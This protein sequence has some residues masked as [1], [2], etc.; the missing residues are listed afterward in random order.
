MAKRSGPARI[1][2]LLENHPYPRDTRV[3]LHAE[4]LASEGYQVTVISPRG[5]GQPG[6][7]VVNGV[8][9]YHFR[10]PTG[11]TSAPAFLLE[12]SVA[13]LMMTLLTLWVWL[14]RGL[15]IL[16]IYN[17][18]DSLFVAGLLPRLMGKTIIYDLRDLAPETYMAKFRQPSQALYRAQLWLERVICQLAHHVVTV[19]ESYRQLV[20]RRDGKRPEQVTIVRQGPNLDRMQGIEPDQ[21]IRDRAGSIIAFL[22]NM[23]AQDGI[24][25]LLQALHHL[26]RLGHTDWY[27]LLIGP[28]DDPQG[29]L[30]MAAELG[31]G[32]RVRL[33][34]LLAG[35][36]WMRLVAAA[37]IGVEPAPSNVINDLCTVNKIMDYMAFS[38]PVV[39]YDLPEHRVTAGDTALYA[40]GND[41]LN[42]AQKIAALIE[43]PALRS[44]L[45]QQGRRRVEE[46]LAWSF[47]RTRLLSLYREIAGGQCPEA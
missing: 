28:A 3:W 40:E 27:C 29:I 12:Y 32:E 21:S 20:I 10:L 47:Q 4:A 7:E 18:P 11:G 1:T 6:H 31:L 13:T 14:R 19:N 15:D 2:I 38:K 37:D 25:H 22:G 9:A 16:T 30:K 36:Q 24:D 34:G 8:R 39:A 33:T 23:S 17:P 5:K 26:G 41:P 35:E 42:F 44:D 46:H 43:A 45:G